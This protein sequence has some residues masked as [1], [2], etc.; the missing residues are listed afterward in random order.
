VRTLLRTVLTPAFIFG[1]IVPLIV[2]YHHTFTCLFIPW[3]LRQSLVPAGVL[4]CVVAAI[5]GV[6]VVAGPLPVVAAVIM[7]PLVGLMFVPG[8]AW[9]W[10]RFSRLR[11]HS[12]LRFESE[13]FRLLQ[14]EL[15]G[16]RRILE[17]AL[18]R[19]RDTGAVRVHYVYEPMRQ[20]GGDLLFVHPQAARPTTGAPTPADDGPVSVVLLDVT[21]H[22]IAAA[23]S[24][25][26]LI[27]ELE[28]LFAACPAAAPSDVLDALNQYVYLTMAR[29]DTYVTAVAMRV[30]P[31]AGR[32]TYA[33]AG[34]PT[35][36]LRRADGRI[37]EL[38][39]T[40]MLLGIVP[41]DAFT[42]DPI[43][44]ELAP[45]D[46]LIAY[47]DG[48]SEARSDDTLEMLGMDG[49]RALIERVAGER[50]PF[51]N[52][53]AEIMRRVAHFRGAPPADD[54]LLVA[55]YRDAC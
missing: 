30:D 23:L 47:T 2:L 5:V 8:S 19:P 27:G 12:R 24:V 29:H 7:L 20:I 6:D 1:A 35:A 42:S 44:I 53:P 41:G 9:C 48:A 16:A 22:G 14:T 55:V 21:G 46:V 31:H 18:P 17:S 45:G 28:R 33:S 13:R 51:Q 37:C 54:T 26:R 10:W 11:A 43:E 36:F 25:N 38:E 52:W 3:T 34:H 39:S 49:V 4:L 40:T 50:H 32:C 15:A